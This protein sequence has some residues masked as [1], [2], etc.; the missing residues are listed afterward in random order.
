MQTTSFHSS[1]L[2]ELSS[3][4]CRPLVRLAIF[5]KEQKMESQFKTFF[6]ATNREGIP[7]AIKEIV[8][9][10]KTGEVAT[11]IVAP[12]RY[13]KSD[14]IRLSA[15]ELVQCGDACAALVLTP[16]DNLA[17]Q[18][19]HE[20]KMHA[21]A[22]R[23]MSRRLPLMPDTFRG[24]RIYSVT[25]TFH[26]TTELQHLFTATLQLVN[27]QT[28][29]FRSWLKQ[30]MYHGARPIIYIDEGQL[31]SNGNEWGK[32]A[33]II[34]D[35]GAHVALLTGTPYRA[36]GKP[37]PGF[38]VSNIRI[39]DVRR[40]ITRRVDDLHVIQS[41]YEGVK[42]EQVL[43]PH[44]EVT[45]REAWDI[46]A[47][48]KVET[49]W[50][51]STLKVDGERVLLSSLNASDATK[52]LRS[53]VTDPQ[54]IKEAMNIAITD[55]RE[56]KKSGMKDAGII[57]I[58]AS[59][60][61]D[62]LEQNDGLANFHARKVRD[63]IKGIDRSLVS[64]IATMADDKDKKKSNKGAENLRRFS[65]DGYGDVLIVKNMGTVGLDCARIKTVVMLG[66][67]RQLAAWVQAILRGATTAGK[68]SHFTLVLTDD[69]KNR[70]NWNFIVR[71]QG[72]NLSSS[73]LEKVKEELLEKEKS[74][75]ETFAEV[76]GSHY[77]R[78]EDSHQS[79]FIT[80]E[81]D[82]HAVIAVH[83]ILRERMSFVEIK[84][85]LKTGAINV[86]KN[87]PAPV[88]VVNTTSACDTHRQNINN[89]S[90]EYASLGGAYVA[91]RNAWV[92]RR[93]AFY[94]DV[95]D[96]AGIRCKLDKE[97]DSVR[98]QVAERYAEKKLKEAKQ[99]DA[100]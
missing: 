77:S 70:D 79:D 44:Y 95:R 86:P 53:V 1:R 5:E 63:Q 7:G 22:N 99:H 68:V 42:S 48:C 60:I 75:D 97:T 61:D 54:T 19:V 2:A 20:D 14:I 8:H 78:T 34:E 57:V 83:P 65:E 39:E 94:N 13:G 40:V 9:R 98:M 76:L 64:V 28:E 59:D 58:T 38:E 55:M 26:E 43:K 25:T 90:A 62:G 47:L 72:G 82:V 93:V 33:S 52:H 88:G 67:Y 66:T 12:P 15:M 16:W 71:D 80:N 89:H 81:D 46:G 29:M 45:L 32:I 96:H 50:I 49:K 35:E 21:M 56:R 74:E 4:R 41:T 69:Q 85:L 87:K 36:D 100:A 23:Y 37:I 51:E 24:G 91:D 10:H 73:E 6:P 92:K 27:N 30:C 17:T 3:Q 31:L 11:A 84:A 18:I